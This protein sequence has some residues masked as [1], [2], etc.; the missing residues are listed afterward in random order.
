MASEEDNLILDSV[1]RW[2]ERDV[3]PYAHDLERRV[4]ACDG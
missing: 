1:R 2:L 4:P 3:A